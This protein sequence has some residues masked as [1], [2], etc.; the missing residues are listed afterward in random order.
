MPLVLRK[1][2]DNLIWDDSTD[3]C[4]WLDE[5]DIASDP[6]T[7]LATKNNSLS[8]YIIQDNRSELSRCLSAL[9]AQRMCLQKLD[10]ILFDTT[11]IDQLQLR[12]DDQQGDLKDKEVNRLHKNIIEL[13]ASK[14]IQLT[15]AIMSNCHKDRLL[16][17][18]V[19]KI[20]HE[21]VKNNWIKKTSLGNELIEDI[22]SKYYPN[23]IGK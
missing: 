18:E 8:I 9:A 23:G 4:P 21:S 13:S 14:L 2:R 11:V 17:E 10:Y 5:N 16:D 19:A 7:D 1:T 12:T 15:K 3:E 20:I 22:E 6:V